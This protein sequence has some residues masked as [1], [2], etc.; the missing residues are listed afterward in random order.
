MRRAETET[1]HPQAQQSRPNNDSPGMCGM[2]PCLLLDNQKHKH[3]Q[4]SIY[5][6]RTSLY[7]HGQHLWHSLL[8]LLSG[9]ISDVV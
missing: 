4:V 6:L 1:A 7:R 5:L 2:S 3:R 8:V 9:D